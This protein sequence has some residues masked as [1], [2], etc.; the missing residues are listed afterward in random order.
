MKGIYR[1]VFTGIVEGLGTVKNILKKANL[2]SITVKSPLLKDVKVGDSVL[3]NGACL[4]ITEFGKDEV[5]VD[6]STHTLQKTTLGNLKISDKVNIERALKV[7]DRLSGHFVTGHVDG[8]AKIISIVKKDYDVIMEIKFPKELKRFIVQKGSISI[9][10]ISLTIAELKEESFE[11][12]VIP[13]TL[14]YTTLGVRKIGDD[15]NIEVDMLA[16]LTQEKFGPAKIPS[17]ITEEFLKE[18]GLK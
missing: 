4:T 18:H 17:K 15:V 14:K 9:D 10:G 6:I 13:H 7:G 2:I 8:I 16:K 12:I 5:T 1:K 3:L 11:V